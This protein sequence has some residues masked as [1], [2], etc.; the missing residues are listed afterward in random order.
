M[1]YVLEVAEIELIVDL[2]LVYDHVKLIVLVVQSRVSHVHAPLSL[3]CTFLLHKDV[4][5]DEGISQVVREQSMNI[6]IFH[7]DKS[8]LAQ[9]LHSNL[10]V[11]ETDHF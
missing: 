5:L 2:D 11:A 8:H 7:I 6:I 4:S 1:E 3:I 10:F 9:T